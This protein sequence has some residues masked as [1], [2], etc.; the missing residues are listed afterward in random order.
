MPGNANCREECAR[1]GEGLPGE[2]PQAFNIPDSF[3]AAAVAVSFYGGP[4]LEDST[5]PTE[6][7]ERLLN[8]HFVAHYPKNKQ[9]DVADG[10]RGRVPRAIAPEG[11]DALR[12]CVGTGFIRALSLADRTPGQRMTLRR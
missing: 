1:G 6:R 12:T 11:D 5:G 10:M 2:S 8:L 9:M 7:A 4:F 3:S